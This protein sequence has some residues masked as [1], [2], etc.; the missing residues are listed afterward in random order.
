MSHQ[1]NL[2][3]AIRIARRN[4]TIIGVAVAVGLIGGA[5]YGSINP[6]VLTAQS[7]VLVQTTNPADEASTSPLGTQVIVV[8]STPVL[9]GA[10]Q[11]LGGSESLN[12]LKNQVTANSPTD[13][14][15]EIDAQGSSAGRA[16]QVANAVANSYVTFVGS[17]ESP[18]GKVAARMLQPASTATGAS[19]IMHRLMSGLI[20]LLAGGVIGFVVALARSRSDRRLRQRDDIANALGIPVL[21]SVP[22]SRPVSAQDWAKLLGGYQPG[23]LHAWRL[24]KALQHLAVA[25][26]NVTGTPR[27]TGTSSVAVVSIAGDQA[28]LALGPQLAVFAVSLGI[29]TS[30]VV[31]P[32]E[33]PNVT[34]A[35]RTACAEWEKKRQ[36]D[37]RVAVVDQGFSAGSV[38]SGFAVIVSVVDGA[39]PK[40]DAT[41]EATATVIGVSAGGVTADQLARVGISAIRSGRD[42]SGILV[43]NPD[44]LDHTTGRAPQLAVPA[45][46]RMPSRMA[47]RAETTTEVRR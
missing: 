41:M 23:V 13:S 21:A 16:E 33:D 26:V 10:Q 47:G 45:A 37:L 1:M 22:A 5:A 28:A 11:T 43:A 3:E 17:S 7:L 31:G 32:Q 46:R 8:T 27:G 30:L 44:P 24:R 36:G 14:V 29:P 6:A 4:K 39:D 40:V 19:P 34:A 2:R 25:G 35:L 20:G 18:V 42:V 9:A 15:L 12:Q 38:A